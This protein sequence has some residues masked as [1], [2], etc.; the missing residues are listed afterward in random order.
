[1]NSP[2]NFEQLVSRC[3]ETHQQLVATPSRVI[4]THLAARNFLFGHY[5][6]HFEQEGADRA[7]CGKQTLR[8]LSEALKAAAGRGFS[9]D[10]LELMRRFYLQFRSDILPAPISETLSRKYLPEVPEKSETASRILSGS[11]WPALPSREM[12]SDLPRCFTLGWSHYVELLTKLR[13]PALRV[14]YAR[15]AVQYSWPRDTLIVQIKNRLHLR[16]G[17]AIT[18]YDKSL[19][20]PQAGLAV[21]LRPAPKVR[22]IPARGKALGSR[23]ASI[24]ALKG[25]PK[26]ELFRHAPATRYAAPS[27]LNS[28]SFTRPRALPWAGMVC[29]VGAQEVSRLEQITHDLEGGETL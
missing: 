4:D 7:H 8:A 29:P 18:N 2:M 24:R 16:Q 19:A 20:S 17:Q 11:E 10:N 26:N 13:D 14:W 27:G 25:R 6:V 12:V 1:M 15:Q 23:F 5:I 28:L 3:H 22:S 9:V 21:D